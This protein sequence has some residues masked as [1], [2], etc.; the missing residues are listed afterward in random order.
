M[1]TLWDGLVTKFGP[2]IHPFAKT[3]HEKNIGVVADTDCIRVYKDRTKLTGQWSEPN[4]S[5]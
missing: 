5:S 1:T 3:H 4:T 2:K